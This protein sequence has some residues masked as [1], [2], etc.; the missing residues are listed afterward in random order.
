MTP[1]EI[2]ADLLEAHK[3][4]QGMPWPITVL[5]PEQCM[6]FS[7]NGKVYHLTIEEVEDEP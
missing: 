4:G 7:H 5:V 2:V 6:E 3:D 1:I